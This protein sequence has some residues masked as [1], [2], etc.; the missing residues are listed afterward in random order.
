MPLKLARFTPGSKIDGFPGNSWN[1]LVDIVET[2]WNERESTQAV[3]ATA[4]P[5]SL[6]KNHRSEVVWVRAINA[7][8]ATIPQGVAVQLDSSARR[9]GK[10]AMLASDPDEH[11]DIPTVGP[12]EAQ[13][14]P[15][16]KMTRTVRS[17]HP[18][19]VT[20]GP[21]PPGTPARVA[22]AGIVPAWVDLKAD[23]LAN[24]VQGGEHTLTPRSVGPDVDGWIR[25]GLPGA[26][27][28]DAMAVNTVL[29]QEYQGHRLCVVQLL[30][31]HNFVMVGNP[32]Q[33]T[34]PRGACVRL[35]EEPLSSTGL[36]PWPFNRDGRWNHAYI[37][38]YPRKGGLHAGPD[39]GDSA[40][41]TDSY[42]FAINDIAPQSWG[43]ADISSTPVAR[44][45]TANALAAGEFVGPVKD[46]WDLSTNQRGFRIYQWPSLPHSVDTNVWLVRVVRDPPP[47]VDP[48]QFTFLTWDAEEEKPEHAWGLRLNYFG[49]LGKGLTG[50]SS[51]SC[52]MELFVNECQFEFEENGRMK[53]NYANL[54]GP[55]L[56]EWGDCGFQVN[57]PPDPPN[58]ADRPPLYLND[59]GQPTINVDAICQ[60]CG[61]GGGNGCA[62]GNAVKSI[63]C[64][65]F[66]EDGQLCL[67]LDITMCDDTPVDPKP[68][69]CID[70]ATPCDP[71][72]P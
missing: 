23:D 18:W 26:I 69:C 21:A 35:D 30:G 32:S 63:A 20:L 4:K 16:L 43:W 67:E 70:L 47:H 37:A 53:L 17:D 19:G 68:R 27:L 36:I 48:C 50:S 25:L 52:V 49:M 59:Q 64:E 10:P 31:P 54:L 29:G 24:I 9:Y 39:Y 5:Q 62:P 72:A 65:L 6:A 33:E 41:I 2:L 14:A 71:P 44:V 46:N 66:I 22:I 61:G 28:L 57:L 40:N 42:A 56:S 11:P 34:I 1:Q 60:E 7:T 12:G 3:T 58:P 15:L 38:R 51:D 45:N 55:G 13:G 8:D